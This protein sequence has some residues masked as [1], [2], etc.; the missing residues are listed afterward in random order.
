MN[1]YDRFELTMRASTPNVNVPKESDVLK[2]LSK[3]NPVIFGLSDND[4]EFIDFL[5]MPIRW[6]N[7]ENELIKVS[8]KFKN[9]IFT[10]HSEGEEAGNIWNEYYF[11]G[12]SFVAKAIIH[13]P[14]FEEIYGKVKGE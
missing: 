7:R 14:S 5:Y 13:I 3:L 12:K 10:L 1:H 8:E 11:N 2:Y 9:V 6:P 4:S